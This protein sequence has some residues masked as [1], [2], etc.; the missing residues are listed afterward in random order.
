MTGAVSEDRAI[1]ILTQGA[2]DYVLKT[3]IAQRLVPAVKRALA[4]AEEHRARRQAEAELREAH[5]TLEERVKTRTAELE[6]EMAV[7]KKIADALQ[8]SERRE[9]ERAEEL[10]TILDAVPTPVIL[11]HDPE[12]THMTGNRSADELLQQQRG[13]EA[14][15][16]APPEVKPRHF[17]AFKGGR[18]LKLDELPAQ[19]A[20][21][22]ERVKDFEFSL[23]FDDGA[24]RELLG[25]GTPLLDKQQRPRGAVN[26]LVDITERKRAEDALKLHAAIMETVAEGIFLIGLDDNIIKW[27]NPKFEQLFGYGP[28]EMVGMHVDKVNAPTERTPTE[29]RISIVDV[30]RKAGE[31]HGEIEN[32]KK[33]G[34]HFWCR[35]HVSLFNHPEFGTVM[36]SAHTDITERK[37]VEDKLQSTLQR[38]Y[39]MLA[40]MYSGFL[41]MT[42]EG[43]IEF[44]N[45]AFCDFY[46]LEEKPAEVIGL[47]SRDLLDRIKHAFL[48][49]AEAAGRIQ[50][51]LQHGQP[52]RN[53]EFVM[54]GR[55]MAMRDFVPLSVNGK[56]CG[57]LWIHTDITERKRMEDKLRESEERYRLLAETML[58]GVVHQDA[59]GDIIAMNPA[60]ELILGKNREQFL[61]SSS[62]DEEHH[63]VRENGEQFPGLEHPSMVALRTGQ[64]VRG[65]VMGVFNPKLDAYRWINIDAV[66]VFRPGDNS[67]SEVYT[68]FEDI[69]GRKKA[70]ET[71]HQ[72]EKR[73]RTLFDSMTEGFAIHEI[74]TDEKDTPTD[75][76]FL[77][78]NPAFERLTGLKRDNVVGRTHS[79]VLP[80]DDPKWLRM[81]GAVALT[82]EPVQFE[83]YSP[84]LNRHY[85][86]LAYRPAPRQFA[87]IFMDI[88]KRK[89]VEK[90]LRERERLLQDVIDGST[91]PIFLKD[92]DGKFITINASLERMLGMSRE[93]IKGKTDYDIAAKEVADYWWTHDKKVMETGKAIQI[94]EVA[95]LQDGHHIFLA[96]KFPLV[97]AEG[98]VYGVG[99]I[100]HDITK[101][102]H[103]EM[104]L[105]ERTKQL[106]D[107]NKELESFGYSVSHDLRAPLRAID[108]YAKMIL[109]QQEH[110]FDEN[111]RHQ[112]DLIRNSAK[113][114]GQ[115]IDDLLALSRLGRE[116][117]SL[118]RLNMEELTRKVWEELK[119]S[120]PDRSID[121]KMGHLPEG[122]GDRSLIKQVLVNILSNAMKFT[123]VRETPLIEVG[124][125]EEGLAVVYYARD[126][127]VGF[128]M[129]HHDNLFGVF[130]RLHST[131][132]YE[133][134]GV[135][136][137]IV[138]RIINRH[139][140][141]VWA[142][143][144][145]A[146][147]RRSISLFRH[148]SSSDR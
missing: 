85:E 119:A 58:Q 90:V 14:S 104:E 83:N 15:L 95:D 22:G 77:D 137:A 141:R 4:E 34:T 69:T 25:Y 48:L 127:G 75:W 27:T 46:G 106:E 8:M 63:T 96:N 26:V 23:V 136:L 61:G 13:S 71:L 70:E 9:R 31:W 94:E 144:E 99:A 53:E 67:P 107:A 39:L 140:G 101:R 97:N 117:L 11:V 76:R 10:A 146:R 72:S 52:V 68:V 108:G 138:Q 78:I 32:I 79:E 59:E 45:Q 55:R 89:Q 123:R 124:G 21:R 102:K 145:V 6:A 30:L 128:D 86:V 60:A 17:K 133:G 42:D 122:M 147:E 120:N 114:M 143:G 121:L 73:Y 29:A 7:R 81:Y 125:Y 91:S 2:K 57:R 40:S 115:L 51:I 33:D 132:E 139:G 80:G 74:I 84:S 49:P 19:R 50:E 20:A 54:Q 130:K 109:K 62:V 88:T 24:T 105:Q 1:D 118:S 103:A 43:R 65:V 148:A 47:A 41:L 28:G 129:Q 66:P 98:Q 38:F 111:T 116:S 16:S 5:R 126:N 100:S 142:E 82:G 18:E 135:G 64:P 93:E 131:A 112:F 113:M 44:V 92:I 87:V 37:Q 134:T 3:R 12:S 56:S 35:I 36:V 110:K